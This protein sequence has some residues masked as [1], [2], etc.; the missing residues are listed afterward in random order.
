MECPTCIEAYN[1]TTRRR[2]VCPFCHFETCLACA[3]YYILSVVQDPHCAHCKNAWPRVFVDDQF[4]KHFVNRELKEHRQEILYEQ[5]KNLMSQTQVNL[6]LL[7]EQRSINEE[8]DRAQEQ[9]VALE[10][11]V[12][13][14]EYK[15]DAIRPFEVRA[16]HHEVMIHCP[17]AD[18]RGFVESDMTC[19]ICSRRICGSCH[20]VAAPD[21][22]CRAETLESVRLMQKD[23]KRCPNCFVRIFKVTGCP[24][25]WCTHCNTGFDWDT[26]EPVRG[27][28]HNPHYYQYLER[29]G[30]QL[31]PTCD[32]AQFVTSEELIYTLRAIDCPMGLFHQ[33]IEVYRHMIHYHQVDLPRLPTRFSHD[34]NI[35]LR[36]RFLSNELS[37][38]EFKNKIQRRQKDTEK[39]IEYRDVME[40]YIFLLNDMF[41]LFINGRAVDE[42]VGHIRA[43][44]EQAQEAIGAL[45]RRYNSSLQPIRA[46]L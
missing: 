44:T 8:I 21:H 34:S 15:R 5:E 39:K 45:N 16:E 33:L 29:H 26:G 46:F 40:T 22:A 42:L 13:E 25:M 17:S 12:S 30:G 41:R 27:I 11:R 24:Q 31:P 20:E 7:H 1:R 19:G 9:I 43:I 38:E 14:L 4:P 10:Q 2:V 28:V 18:C 35:D 32:Q 3:E 36:I 23:T 37:E 6:K